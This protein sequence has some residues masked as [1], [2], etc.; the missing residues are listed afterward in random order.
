MKPH[1]WHVFL[2]ENSLQYIHIYLSHSK[3]GYAQDGIWIRE[4]YKA[5]LNT[6][7]SACSCRDSNIY[8]R[9]P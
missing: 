5:H 6:A 8:A 4:N 7:E 2:L 3:P 1:Y 9:P